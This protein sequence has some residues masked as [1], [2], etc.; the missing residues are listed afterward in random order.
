MKQ[1][2]GQ[3]RETAMVSREW[4]QGPGGSQIFP[5]E[6]YPGNRSESEKTTRKMMSRC[7]GRGGSEGVSFP[8]PL[9]GLPCNLSGRNI[10]RPT[11][12]SVFGESLC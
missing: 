3:V 12:L 4:A 10:A 8:P 6:Y 11:D 9:L 1:A 7:D 2:W 5:G